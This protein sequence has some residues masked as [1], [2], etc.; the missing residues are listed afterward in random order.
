MSSQN[1]QIISELLLGVTNLNENIRSVSISKLQE[2]YLHNF[3]LLLFCLL[4][5][6]E[7]TSISTKNNQDLLKTTSLVIC[8]KIIEN[9]DYNTWKNLNK[10]LKDQI[11]TKL[12]YLLN[13]EIYLKD[14]I[15]VCDLI[16]ELLEKIFEGRGIWPEI[17]SLIINIY[18]Y[19]PNQGDKNSLQI[20]INKSK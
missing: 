7:K 16:I 10:E 8:R 20:I 2:L 17:I 4:E 18:K 1:I 14:N 9:V 13:N 11:K 19:D 12:L 15:K 3:D 5:I 6:I